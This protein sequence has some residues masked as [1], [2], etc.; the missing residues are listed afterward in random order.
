[1][2]EAKLRCGYCGKAMPTKKILARDWYSIGR[3]DGDIYLACSIDHAMGLF[4]QWAEYIEV[5][6]QHLMVIETKGNDD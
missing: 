6:N 2:T 4:S 1:M 3:G 5:N